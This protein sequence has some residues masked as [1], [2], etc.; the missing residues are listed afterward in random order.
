MTEKMNQLIHKSFVDYFQS[1]N[2]T[3]ESQN[4]EHTIGRQNFSLRYEKTCKLQ[5]S[6]LERAVSQGRM[7]PKATTISLGCYRREC[8]AEGHSDRRLLRVPPMLW[9]PVLLE[10]LHCV[11]SFLI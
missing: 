6:T 2:N 3:L 7:C 10:F 11:F 8:S 4:L 9:F 1:Q 5:H